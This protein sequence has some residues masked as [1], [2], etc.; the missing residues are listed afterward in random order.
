MA[1][2]VT[3][4]A[5]LIDPE[6]LA[7]MI[8]GKLESKI[9]VSSFSKI[10]TSLQ[11]VPGDTVTI[12]KFGYIGDAEDVPEG[13]QID[14]SQLSTTKTEAK[15]K[16]AM[17]SVSITDE[18]ALSGLGN[19][20]GQAG[21][22]IVKAIASKLDSD[23]MD[24][25]QDATYKYTSDSIINYAGIVNAIDMFT[26]EVQSEKVMFVHPHQVTQLRLDPN[27]IS[28]DKYDNKVIM[29]GEIGN[30]AGTRIVPSK[31]VPVIAVAGVNYYACPIVKLNEDDETEDELPATTIYLK[32][33]TVVET[34]RVPRKALTEITANKFY[35]VA[36]TNDE[37]VVLAK[38]LTGEADAAADTE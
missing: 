24:T 36:L 18:A 28:A 25:L 6:V 4:L 23:A 11:G 5:A 12:P 8:S 3:T 14:T 2:L 13:E 22:Q 30:I 27:F 34:E 31:K 21:S 16:K 33:D 19:P 38:F 15:I 35:T 37:K 9:I 26:E 17:K 7:D 29:N 32:R 10:D 20:V 1:D